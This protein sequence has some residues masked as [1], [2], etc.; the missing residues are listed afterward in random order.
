M[1]KYFKIAV[2]RSETTEIYIKTNDEVTP[3]DAMRLP[4]IG[5][6]ALETTDDILDWCNTGWENDVEVI[7][8]VEVDEKE[9][10]QFQVYD[11]EKG[12]A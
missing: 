2:S 7:G 12:N 8:C 5:K 4:D 10:T 1:S 3:R 6:A 9:A 11:A